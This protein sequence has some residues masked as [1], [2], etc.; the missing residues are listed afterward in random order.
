[1]NP[2]KLRVGLFKIDWTTL[3]SNL[4]GIATALHNIVVIGCQ[5]HP[6]GVGYCALSIDDTF[7]WLDLADPG[8]IVNAQV[9]ELKL[10]INPDGTHTHRWIKQKAPPSP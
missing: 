8:N 1:M 10:G 9:Y 6:D 3:H 4:P 7:D 2:T 5:Q